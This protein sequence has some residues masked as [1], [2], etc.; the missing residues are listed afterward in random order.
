MHAEIIDELL[1]TFGYFYI[2]LILYLQASREDISKLTSGEERTD[3][4]P[5]SEV[6]LKRTVFNEIEL[7]RIVQSRT[8]PEKLSRIY[9]GRVSL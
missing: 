8:E 3:D 9:S 5:R 6:F 7:L 2:I 1:L 4:E